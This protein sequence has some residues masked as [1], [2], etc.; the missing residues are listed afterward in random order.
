MTRSKP[1]RNRYVLGGDIGG[2]KTALR[3]AISNPMRPAR[4]AEQ[5]Y[6]SQAYRSLS[7]II[8]EFLRRAGHDGDIAS[9]CFAVAGP[10]LNQSAK[11]TN[12]PWR[13]TA[14]EISARFGIESVLLINDFQ[15]VAVGLEALT[16]SHLI[17]LQRGVK[18]RTG[19]RLAVGAGTGLGVAWA[20]HDAG[21]IVAHAS[22]AGHTG[23]APIGEAQRE[24]LR[25]LEAKFGRVSSERVLSGPGLVNIFEFLRAEH[26][27]SDGLNDALADGDDAAAIISD[28]A[29][30]RADSTAVEALDM[31]ASIYGAF[32]GDM[33]LTTLP[34]GGVYIAGGIAP[35]IAEKLKDGAFIRAFR[36]KGRFSDLLSRVPVYIVM[37]PKAG[38]LGATLLAHRALTPRSG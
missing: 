18:A 29:L 21:V 9:A 17:T 13:I 10:V 5:Q 38:L 26:Q 16:T 12:L 4:I 23:F 28:F 36:D 25:Y 35:K 6:E 15:A 37:T 1:S 19:T 33:A 27:V 14:A 11:L 7:Q 20:S 3:L 30:R 24:L 22:E 2:T 32:A 8:T 31:M 34:T